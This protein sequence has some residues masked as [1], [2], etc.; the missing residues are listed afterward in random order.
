[1]IWRVAEYEARQLKASTIEPVHLLIALC[2]SVDLDLPALVSDKRPDRDEILEELL[3]E[4]RK[5]RSIFRAAGLGAKAF[6]RRLR[7]VLDGGIADAGPG[8]SVEPEPER[9]RRSKSAKLVF[10]DAEHFAELSAHIVYPVH[11]LFAVL[12]ITD[13]ER[14]EV[15]EE[16][17]IDL[18][19]LRQVAKRE[20]LLRNESKSFLGKDDARLN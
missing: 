9:L 5:L 4:V 6:R 12:Q 11:L 10:A 18:K 7:T 8:F 1:M 13:A 20:V 19:R 15:M 3:S 17:G 14:D 2:K 16:F